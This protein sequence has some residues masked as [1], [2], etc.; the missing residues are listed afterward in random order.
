MFITYLESQQLAFS[1]TTSKI[2]FYH[3]LDT[4]WI[5]KNSKYGYTEYLNMKSWCFII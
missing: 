1:N 4:N 5:Y 2:K 3:S